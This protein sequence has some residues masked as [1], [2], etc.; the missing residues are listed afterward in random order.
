MQSSRWHDYTS[1]CHD[2]LMH[3][4][5]SP[6]GFATDVTEWLDSLSDD[7]LKQRRDSAELAIQQMGITFT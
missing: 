3:Q 4:N 2:E 5:G 7:A 6:R 1:P